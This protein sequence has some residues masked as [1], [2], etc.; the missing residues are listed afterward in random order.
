MFFSLGKR[1]EAASTFS[2]VAFVFPLVFAL[3]FFTRSISLDEWDSYQ[4]AM[5]VREFDLWKHQPH[6]PGYPLYIFFG[7]IGSHFFHWDPGF[8]LKLVSCIGGALF[9]VAWFAI[10]RGQFNERF[11]WLVAACLTATP[12]VWMTSTKVLSDSIATAF[13]SLELLCALRYRANGKIGDLLGISLFGATAAGVRPQLIAVVLIILIVFLRQ[14]RAPTRSWLL[15]IATLLA[16]C[17][18]WLLPMWIMQARLS[19][20]V[21]AISVY[22]KQLLQQWSW[23]LDKPKV[24]I[25]A[26]GFSA[27]YFGL[28]FVT[29]F[30]GWFGLG[31][32]F[33]FSIVTLVSG[34]L[35]AFAGVINYFRLLGAEDRAFWKTHWIWA[36]IYILIIFCC[37]PPYQRYYLIAIPLLL[38]V[39][40]RGLLRL[41]RYQTAAVAAFLILLLSIS[42][43]LAFKSHTE[44]A[45]VR[46]FTRY[47]EEHY[48]PDERANVFLLLSECTRPVQWYAPQ[49]KIQDL[50]HLPDVDIAEMQRS[51]AVYTDDPNLTLPSGWRRNRL[52]LF[53]RSILI[54]P[55]HRDIGVYKIERIVT[56]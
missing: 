2:K 48:Q 41:P 8:S 52:A 11:A 9:V 44:E 16:A 20:D 37:L 4:F 30:F 1:L 5:G 22:P 18:C 50:D 25:G 51:L 28:K 26:Q 32:G 13:L 29:H 23:R 38:V 3:Y 47:L 49:F 43:P 55:K 42:V 56:R 12:I 14:R 6:P 7:W 36:A 46:K 10:I 39:L 31:F 35:L 45:P 19:P 40:L 15:G 53:H 33:I 34:T 27:N 54:D 21:S 24:F 17:C